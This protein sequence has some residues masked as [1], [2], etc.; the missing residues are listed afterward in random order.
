MK[1]SLNAAMIWISLL[2][3]DMSISDVLNGHLYFVAKMSYL[4][5]FDINC[6][7]FSQ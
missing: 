2:P 7:V 5:F 6:V 4:E 1:Y 3:S